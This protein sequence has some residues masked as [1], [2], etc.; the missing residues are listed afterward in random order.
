MDFSGFLFSGFRHRAN[1][2]DLINLANE[3]PALVEI[4]LRLFEISADDAI[5]LV[6]QFK[7]L[8]KFGFN[9]VDDVDKRNYLMEHLGNEWL[10][11][12][13]GLFYVELERKG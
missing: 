11:Q 13:S 4:N 2:T 1:A 7:S 5:A 8:K 6:G 10:V 3:H 9:L 12:P